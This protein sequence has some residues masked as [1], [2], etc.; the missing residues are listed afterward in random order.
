MTERERIHDDAAHQGAVYDAPTEI[1]TLREPV[2]TSAVPQHEAATL[3]VTPTDRA[4][5]S[6]II[7]GLFMAFALLTFLSVLAMSVGISS[8]D[9]RDPFRYDTLSADLLGAISALVAFGVG[10]WLAAR[11]AAVTG[12]SNGLL[13]SVLVW[14]VAMPLLL[15]LFGGSG[16]LLS[17]FGAAASGGL[18]PGPAPAPGQIG[19]E[20]LQ[21]Q[22]RVNQIE[23]LIYT[24]AWG[25]PLAILT[26]FGGA[27]LGGLLGA[28]RARELRVAVG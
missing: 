12:Y 25:T 8:F 19:A 4:R 9:A 15:F 28:R 14:L 24:A 11:A 23:R 3:V 13:N 27:L 7:A 16:G 20:L 22:A 6:A 2:T 10:G 1:H 18:Q 26:G 17:L 5:W 21:N